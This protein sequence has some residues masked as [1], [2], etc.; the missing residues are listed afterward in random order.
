MEQTTIQLTVQEA[1]TLLQ[2]LD[3]AVRHGGR[4]VVAAVFHFDVK[5]QQ[6]I[7]ERGAAPPKTAT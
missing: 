4:P 7:N 6:F 5:L 1:Q 2:L 3:L